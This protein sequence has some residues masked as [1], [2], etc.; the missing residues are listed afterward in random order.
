MKKIGI[1]CHIPFCVRKCAYCD[2]PSFGIT[3]DSA[4]KGYF[5]ALEKEIGE[6]INKN[7]NDKITVDT[8]YFG[9]GTPSAVEPE[10]LVSLMAL[11]QNRFDV[12]KDAEVT[13]EINP[14]TLTQKKASLYKKAGFNRVSMG[15]QAW[16]NTLLK[17]LGRIH[18]QQEFIESMALLKNVGF[19]NIS[20]DLMYGLPNQTIANVRETL[21]AVMTFSPK[22]LSCYSLILEEN[23]PMTQAFNE[24]K[25][26]LPDEDVERLMHWEVHNFLEKQG[27]N[28]YEISSYAKSGYESRHNLK[29]WDEI[30]YLGFGLAAHSFYKGIRYGNTVD[31]DD[32]IKG[33]FLSREFS[34]KMPLTQEEEM[35]EWMLLGL[36]KLNGIDDELFKERFGVSFFERYY[37]TIDR[38]IASGLVVKEGAILRLTHLGQDFGNQVFMG[39]L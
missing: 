13:I 20:V 33:K 39:F 8:I 17:S 2:F 30:P 28:H 12:L 4:I 27:Y 16:Q 25:I 24:G 10:Y 37:E 3:K 22:H 18:T 23:T 29:Y 5:L 26:K 6:F 35:N 7:K 36:R 32:Y 11:I 38:F 34:G 19:E 14:G 15:L 31:L 1:Y 21:R 9:G